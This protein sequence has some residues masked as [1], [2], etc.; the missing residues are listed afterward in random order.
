MS[1]LALTLR[2]AALAG[3]ALVAAAP[4][5]AIKLENYQ[6]YRLDSRSVQATFKSMIEVRI[7]GVLQGLG[8]RQ[9]RQHAGRPALA[10]RLERPLHDIG[11]AF[12]NVSEE[13][14]G[15]DKHQGDILRLPGQQ[16]FA[17]Y[18]IDVPADIPAHALLASPCHLA[19]AAMAPGGNRFERKF[20][21]DNQHLACRRQAHDAI[22]PAVVGQ[23]WLKS[24]GARRQTVL[25]DGFKPRLA[26]SA[27]R[28]LVG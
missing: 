22:G 4:A 21:I 1:T 28:L 27:A 10:P 11:E 7:E 25:Y 26:E 5:G 3:A 9:G 24:I 17:R 6:K 18:V 16:I 2:T 23:R 20:R 8:L 13:R 14:F 12:L 15:R 19:I